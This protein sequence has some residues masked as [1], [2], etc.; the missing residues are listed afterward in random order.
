MFLCFLWAAIVT[1][2]ADRMI[3]LWSIPMATVTGNTLILKPSERDPGAAMIIAELCQRAG[4]PP[5]VINVVHG[6]VPTVNAICDHPSIKAISFVGGDRA[7]RHIY[8]RQ[9]FYLSFIVH[10]LFDTCPSGT[11][12]G[13]RVQSNMGAK[14]HAILMPDGRRMDDVSS[15]QSTY[16]YA[17]L[18]RIMPSTPSLARLLA[19]SLPVLCD[20]VCS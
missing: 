1:T 17:Q 13:K 8:E 3:P 9:V 4:L 7:G 2:N 6:T 11:K 10:A 14:N 16:T 20:V 19:V 5:G 15:M 12:N 18:T